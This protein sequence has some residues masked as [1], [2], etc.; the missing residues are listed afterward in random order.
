MSQ[1][2]NKVLS[3]EPIVSGVAVPLLS[4]I[5]IV[6]D[7]VDYD[8]TSLEEGFFIEG[9]SGV[10]V[11]GIGGLKLEYPEG[12]PAECDR[13][14][15]DTSYEQAAPIGGT[16]TVVKDVNTTVT[17]NPTYPLAASVEHKANLTDVLDDS[18]ATISGFISWSFT[19]GT[20]SIESL[21]EEIS[22]SILSTT[23]MGIA[24]S[25]FAAPLK[26][27]KTTPSDHAI[28]QNPSIEE[29]EIEFNKPIDPSSISADTIQITGLPV[30]DHPNISIKSSGDLYKAVEVNGKKVKLKI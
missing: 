17:F 19:T 12:I 25:L 5:T 3:Y 20:G 1:L 30:T 11:F 22:S 29:I 26:V 14:I 21:P 16:V 13:D 9:P 18:L 23:S 8:S 10:G 27:V 2:L 15:F 6:L 24:G 7:G 28:Q 4:N